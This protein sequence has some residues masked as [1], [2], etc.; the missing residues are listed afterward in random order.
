MVRHTTCALAVGVLLLAACGDNDPPSEAELVLMT[1]GDTL[2]PDRV[3]R[4]GRMD[5]LARTAE[6]YAK[7]FAS[8]Q[9]VV[10]YSFMPDEF[11]TKCSLSDY[12]GMML[13]IYS[14][15]GYPEDSKATLDGARARD[16]YGW[17]DIDLEK[18]GVKLEFP[19][20]DD[21]ETPQFEWHGY[22]WLVHVPE[23]DL[24]ND[25]PCVLDDVQRNA[26]P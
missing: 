12:A 7:A 1:E 6:T 21:P 24:S 18:D 3:R 23:D 4:V 25:N 13:Y 10:M 11:K 26:T 22:K 20:P 2:E 16:N 5:M 14:I 15:F 19:Q 9:W 8:Q 17:A